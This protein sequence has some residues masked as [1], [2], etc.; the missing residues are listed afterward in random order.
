MP[1]KFNGKE[2]DEETGLYYYGARY[3]DAK[4]CR[5]YG[6]DP[7][8]EKYTEISSYAYCA[9]NPIMLI[10]PDG[11]EYGDPDSGGT[12][13]KIDKQTGNLTEAQSSIRP[14]LDPNNPKYEINH[15]KNISTLNNNTI[16]PNQTFVGP[17][18]PV[19]YNNAYLKKQETIRNLKLKT[20]EF[21]SVASKIHPISYGGPNFGIGAIPALIEGIKQAPLT[22]VAPELVSLRLTKLAKPTLRYNDFSKITTG[23]FKGPMHNTLRG[24]AYQLYKETMNSPL[25]RSNIGNLINNLGYASDIYSIGS[26]TTNNVIL[27]DN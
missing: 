22:I 4:E 15:I 1:Y 8:A 24:N 21:N 17:K 18:N 11:M 16:L 10:D 12:P 5:F 7:M 19:K 13:A 26:Y 6:V 27:N 25:L 9:N 2:Q 14:V 3:Y 23:I 20:E